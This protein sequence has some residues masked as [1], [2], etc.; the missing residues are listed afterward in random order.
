MNLQASSGAV[1]VGSF[2]LSSALSFIASLLAGGG[3]SAHPNDG[4][5]M[6]TEQNANPGPDPGLLDQAVKAAKG[7]M[8]SKSATIPA[9]I[10]VPSVKITAKN[11]NV[12]SGSEVSVS[13]WGLSG[14]SFFGTG[15]AGGGAKH[16][17]GGSH[18]GLGGF[19]T[20]ASFAEQYLGMGG[21]G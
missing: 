1:N 16:Q 18:A 5:L 12:S 20:E 21:R 4:D 8:G 19:P 14:A 10:D 9:F 17:F 6:D 3:A 2:S 11:A 13:G 15:T 7:L